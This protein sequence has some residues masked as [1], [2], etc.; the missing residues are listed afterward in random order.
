MG[1]LWATSRARQSKD[2]QCPPN[3]RIQHTVTDSQV[4]DQ[5]RLPKATRMPNAHQDSRYPEFGVRLDCGAAPE[6]GLCRHAFPDWLRDS[7]KPGAARV[8]GILEGE[9]I[10][11]ELMAVSRHILDKVG[12]RAGQRFDVRTG[13]E[14]GTPAWK[15]TGNWVTGEVEAFCQSIHACGGAVLCGPG[16]GRFV[17]ELRRR[18]ALFCK[19][20]PLRPKAPLCDIGP[21]RPEAVKGVDIL[22]VRE[23]LGGLYQG[24]HREDKQD[25]HLRV[26][27]CFEYT[28][29][30]VRH[31][32]S[33]GAELARLRRGRLCVVYKPGGVPAV[34]ELWREEASDLCESSG[35]ALELLEID[36]ACYQLIADA[37]R[38]DVVVASNMFG[39]VLADAAAVLLGSRGMSFSAN[40]SAEGMGI[41]QTAH[42]AAH[43][44]AGLDRANPIGQIDSLVFMLREH[45]ALNHLA[46]CIE[47]G[48]IEVLAAGWRTADI[49]GP[50]CRAVGTRRMGEL[51][52]E[53][54]CR[55]LEAA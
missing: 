23:N 1:K 41:Y 16:G 36:N 44:L 43:D 45:F 12:A 5:T 20:V 25:G 46:S 6:G 14:I 34:S 33:I 24:R 22:V 52:A 7:P 2:K 55:C 53:A 17:Y 39:D 32:V 4:T 49:M 38:F 18:L 15:S 48:V 19:L 13:S 42:G 50:G 54:A 31:V 9:G 28:Q 29:P 11:P 30:Q 21:L 8:V 3:Y 26:R 47:Q 10:G 51:I 27:H 35:V 37:A 40:F